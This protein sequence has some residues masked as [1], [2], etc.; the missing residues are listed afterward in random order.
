MNSTAQPTIMVNAISTLVGEEIER[1]RAPQ[2]Q[3]YCAT[4]ASNNGCIYGIPCHASQVIKFDPDRNSMTFIRPDFGDYDEKWYRGAITDSGVIYGLPLDEECG[5][6]KIDTNTDNVTELN[7]N[8][9]PEEGWSMWASCAAALDGCIYCMPRDARQIMK[10][11]PNK[12]DAMTSVGDDLGGRNDKYCGTVVGIDGCVYGIPFA[13]ELMII[14]YDPI[15]DKTS[16]LGEVDD[17]CSVDCTHDG[18]LG[19]DGC[20]YALAREQCV[21][22]GGQVLKID[23]TNNSHCFVGN[24]VESNRGD[25]ADVIDW[26]DAI[27]GTDG[28][29][30]WPPVNATHILK[31]DPYTNQTSLVGDDYGQRQ[32]KWNGGTLAADGVIYCLPASADQVLS[33]DPWKEFAMNVKNNMNGHHL[34]PL[35]FLFQINDSDIPASNR[36][37]FDCAVTKFGIDKV[38]EVLE[39][40]MPPVDRV[41]SDSN[42]YPFMM[43]ASYEKSALSVIYYLLR[44]FPSLLDHACMYHNEKKRKHILVSI[45]QSYHH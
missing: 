26:G 41:C 35:R 18:A 24:S 33:I 42:L 9:L 7:V 44:Q 8:L 30:Y 28:C 19:R 10:I 2:Q 23:T 15:N 12:N 31:H 11:D 4:V 45:E 36:T 13:C 25:E 29:I 38:F 22:T 34:E 6:L 5:I 37:Y 17:V 3:N 32:F 39:E 14:K 1:G 20:I 21:V 27:S 40:Y 43:A 16:F